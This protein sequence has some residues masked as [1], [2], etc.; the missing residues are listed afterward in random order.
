MF[1]GIIFALLACCMWGFI[2]VVPQFIEGFHAFEVA[3]ARY[4]MYGI[5]SLLLF[6]KNFLST[7]RVYPRAIWYQAFLVAFI[8]NII[9]YTSVIMG[10]KYSTPAICALILGVSPIVTTLYANS[11]HREHSFKKFIFPSVLIFFGLLIINFPHLQATEKVDS[12]LSYGFGL[13]A[14]IGGLLTWSWYVVVNAN[15]LKRHPQ[16]S[17]SEWATLVGVATL[18]V[19]LLCYLVLGVFLAEKQD[20]LRYRPSTTECKTLLVGASILA[21]FCSWLGSYFW[22]H[23]SC[24]LP[25][26]LAGQLTIFET[27]FGLIFVSILEGQVPPVLDFFA[28]LMILAAVIY[29]IFI[30]SSNINLPKNLA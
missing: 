12:S 18:L 7:P 25:V 5:I 22:N 26:T 16:I 23:A 8:A 24:L 29:G 21:I 1:Q 19:V 15:F 28:I 27:I 17:S 9:Y 20:F 2:F 3:L 14:S 6:A 11:V 13:L 10:L 30:S 4:F